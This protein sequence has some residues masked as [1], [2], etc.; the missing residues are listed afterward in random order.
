MAAINGSLPDTLQR[1]GFR[2][3]VQTGPSGR[4]LLKTG[5]QSPLL[6]TVFTDKSVAAMESLDLDE[7]T[8]GNIIEEEIDRINAKNGK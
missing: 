7:R 5:P 1:P 6:R 8:F 3:F 4:L 2:F